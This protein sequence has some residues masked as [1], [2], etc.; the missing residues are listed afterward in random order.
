VR[1]M[2][3][4]LANRTLSLKLIE[5]GRTRIAEAFTKQHLLAGT[6]SAYER[7]LGRH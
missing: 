4:V 3:R 7:A 5:N 1:A 6:I 2:R